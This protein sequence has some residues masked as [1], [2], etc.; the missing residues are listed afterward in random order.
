MDCNALLAQ[1]PADAD[2]R[3]WV[4]E[5]FAQIAAEIEKRDQMISS[6]D[7]LV[8]QKDSELHAARLK[9]E[10]ITLE[11]AHLR[12][13]RFGA[14]SELVHSVHYDLFDETAGTDIA[15]L[16]AEIDASA[17]QPAP[18]ERPSRDGPR[19]KS[20]RGALPA[21]LPRIIHQHDLDADACLCGACNSALTVIGEDISEQLDVTPA[22]F[23]V[24]QH[25]RPQYA[26]KSCQS[27]T[28]APVPAAVI[29]G[30]LAAPGLIAW[31]L[32]SKFADHLP[33]YRLEQIAARSGVNLARSTLSH[34]VGRF[35]VAL[36]PLVDRLRE[37]LKAR[38]VLHA[39]ETP[40]Q[41]LAPGKG[42]TERAYLW[43][44]C[45]S[46]LEAV[47]AL[48]GPD[49]PPQ[50]PPP[51]HPPLQRPPAIVVFDYQPGRAGAHARAFLKDWS[52]HLMVDDYVG[53]KALFAQTTTTATDGVTNAPSVIELGCM[54]HARR[55]FFELHAAN[56]S[57]TALSAL[58]QIAALYAIETKGRALSST[59][60][61][62]LRQDEAVP[63]LAQMKAWLIQTRVNTP[64]GGA[65]AKE[66]DYSLRRW[67]ALCRYA[68]SG[69]LP[70]DNNPI[71]NAIRPIAIGKKNWL[72]AG[73]ER[74]GKRAAAIQSLFATAKRNHLDP[75]AWLKDVLEKLPTWPN[76]RIDELLPFAGY[77][78]G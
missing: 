46:E 52:G 13:M 41:Q 2:V 5:Q 31:A 58:N 64:N 73:S 54:A 35:G 65:L 32:T 10:A 68:H 17:T 1:K 47:E 11:L 7:Q 26:C 71:E 45:S 6:R 39:D 72:F 49:P 3:G 76:R 30:G 78:F 44:Y 60:R 57:P 18:A 14:T 8:A 34:W 24:H 29:D 12:R 62:R 53:Y 9:I 27:V 4:V 67:E 66:I 59:D 70:I 69:H 21:H 36:Q 74:A 63:L 25:I 16:E 48:D 77:R 51:Q 22:A 28:A 56:G 38:A 55:K 75:H 43:A 50:H 15:A 19:N 23:F 33:L 61:K 20:G 40:V 42:K 37:L